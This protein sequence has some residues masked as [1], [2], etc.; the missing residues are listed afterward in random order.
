MNGLLCRPVNS[1]KFYNIFGNK[2]KFHIFNPFFETAKKYFPIFLACQI[3]KM[4]V[5]ILYNYCN[6]TTLYGTI[7]DHGGTRH[8]YSSSFFFASPLNLSPQ[9][10]LTSHPSHLSPLNS[11]KITRFYKIS[12]KE[13]QRERESSR[14]KNQLS[15]NLRETAPKNQTTCKT[16]V[17]FSS[18]KKRDSETPNNQEVAV[19]PYSVC[20]LRQ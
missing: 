14:I 10:C 18:K 16:A 13:R 11:E 5:I 1:M 20:Q 6:H 7:T 15:E 17:S 2:L 3:M 8:R 4:C 9:R 12:Q 19:V